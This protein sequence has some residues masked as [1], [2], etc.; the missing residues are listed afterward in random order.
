MIWRNNQLQTS[1]NNT[2]NEQCECCLSDELELAYEN[3][4]FNL[5]ILK[6]KTCLLHFIWDKDSSLDLDKYYNE[7]YWKVF[8]N[9][10][11][12][13]INDEKTDNTYLVKKLPK[14]I[15]KLV[16]FIG[17]RKS[18]SYSQL[19][20]L[21]PY[22]RNKKKLFE[23]GSGEGF[24]LEFFEKEGLEVFGLE[25][26]KINL[27]IINKKLNHSKVQTGSSKDLKNIQDTFDIIVLSHVLEHL[28]S[29][30][31]VFIEL[32]R[33]LS[34][35]GILFIDVPNCINYQELQNSINTQPHTF[36]FSKKSL[37]ELANSCGF[38]VIKSEIYYGKVKTISD[39][40][41][42][43]FFWI[44]KKD[45]F[46]PSDEEKGNYIRLVITHK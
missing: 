36:H 32:K 13:D 18:L 17:V 24:I 33:I 43:L 25:P 19:K 14:T 45:Y 1:L 30:R 40:L 16:D 12:E 20:Y 46:L 38:K 39:H 10:K 15:Q 29:C 2:I 41:K 8:R 21:K 7:T 44:L 22:I 9:L 6:C 23:L 31:D 11:N 5:P 34:K 37:N 35:N 26:S 28:K 42:Y 3:S 27:K 4:F